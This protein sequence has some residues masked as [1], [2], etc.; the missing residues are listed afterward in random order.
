M[1]LTADRRTAAERRADDRDSVRSNIQ[2]MGAHGALLYATKRLA[3][4]PPVHVRRM[5]VLTIKS[6][7]K[8][9]DQ[10]LSHAK[11]M[12]AIHARH[13][14]AAGIKVPLAYLLLLA[15]APA[16][17]GPLAG[18]APSRAMAGRAVASTPVEAA[19]G[20][21]AGLCNSGT[22]AAEQAPPQRLTVVY[23]NVVDGRPVRDTIV[24]VVRPAQ[25]AAP[26]PPSITT[27]PVLPRNWRPPAGPTSYVPPK[28]VAATT[29]ARRY[30]PAPAPWFINGI[31]AGPSPSGTW[32]S[33]AVGRPIVDVRIIDTP[34]RRPR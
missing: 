14:R 28:P 23:T 16:T 10:D 8:R 3:E 34:P 4:L 1:R 18:G 9:L 7:A 26:V 12:A 27:T 29:T 2:D 21:C 11:R 17:A 13:L 15:A 31:Y 5:L 20:R 25:P 22:A 30:R 19:G 32:M 24:A 6:A 33:T